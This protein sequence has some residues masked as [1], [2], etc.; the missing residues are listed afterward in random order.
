MFVLG[1]FVAAAFGVVLIARP[2]MG[3]F[4]L[5]LL[6]GLFNLISGSWMLVCVLELRRTNARLHAVVPP[7]KMRA[8]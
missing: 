8:A 1:G 4:S 2:A 5:A 6:F 7:T 3:A